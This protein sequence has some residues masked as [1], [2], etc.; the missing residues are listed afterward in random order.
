MEQPRKPCTED[1]AWQLQPCGHPGP[2]SLAAPPH[3]VIWGPGTLAAPPLKVIWV[4]GS[5]AAP[6]PEVIWGPG[7]LAAPPPVIIQGLGSLAAP[8]QWSSRAQGAWQLR[9]LW[10]SGAQAV[11]S[12]AIFNA[13]LS[14]LLCGSSLAERNKIGIP[15]PGIPSKARRGSNKCS[16]TRK[17]QSPAVRPGCQRAWHSGHTSR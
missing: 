4:P 2:G 15:V 13:C 5:L 14:G 6:P 3:K 17:T 9:P 12:S 16:V 1:A 11:G 8:P 7:S 10:S